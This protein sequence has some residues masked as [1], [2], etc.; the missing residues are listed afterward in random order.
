MNSIEFQI[1]YTL[2]ELHTPLI[3]GLMVFITSLGDHGWFWLLM[4]VLLFSFPRT[5]LLGG[6]M[7]ISIAAGFLLGNVLLKNIAARQRPCWLDPSVK[8]LVRV[9]GDFSFPSGHSLVSFEGAV[10]IFLFNRKWGIPA[11]MLAVLI[12]FSRLYLFV[13]FPTD[14]LAG[15]VMGTAIAWTV[16]RTV[17]R[18]MENRARV[19]QDP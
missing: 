1:L 10:C 16:V 14:V 4:G 19:P 5:G 8:L 2:Q 17:K 3:D 12:A 11:L 7:L 18:R 6:C 15:I 9:P 13:H